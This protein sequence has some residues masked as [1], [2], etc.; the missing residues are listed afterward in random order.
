MGHHPIWRIGLIGIGGAGALG[1]KGEGSREVHRFHVSGTAFRIHLSTR[2]YEVFIGERMH[3][4]L[5]V[6]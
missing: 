3:V 6:Y 2:L 4:N 5:T 1:L